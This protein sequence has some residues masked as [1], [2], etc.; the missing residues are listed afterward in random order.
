[1]IYRHAFVLIFLSL[2][3]A[4]TLSADDFP[5]PF[6]TEKSPAKLTTP[7]DALNGMTVPEG[8]E[9]SLF[10]AEPDVNQPIALA[11]DDR[12]RLWV[13][14][15]YTYSESA[16]NYD[17]Q[18][19]DRVVILE[20]AD[21]DGSF[22]KRTVFWD[23]G[24]RLTSVEVGH[25]GVW[26]LDAPN[27]LFIPDANKDDVPDGEPVVMLDGWD[28]NAARHT[29]VNGLRWGPDGWLYGR[30][31]I[32]AISNVGIPGATADQRTQIDCGIWR[33]HPTRRKF[34]VVCVG[35]TNP[36][37]MDWDE[38]GQMFF[39][40]TVI[41]HLWHV[42]P[43]ARFR[44][45]YGEHFNPHTYG[46]IE[47]TADHFHWDTK[48]LWH[49][50]RKD[51]KT[52]MTKTTDQA[53]GGHAH[54]G[55]TILQGQPFPEELH[56]S[57]LALNLHGRRINRD[58]L[59]RHGATYTAKHAPDFLKV[60]DPWYRGVE[61]ICGRVGE[62]FIAD[63]SDV[64][65]CHENDGIHRTSGRIYRLTVAGDPSKHRPNV[66]PADQLTSQQLAEL[67]A[68]DWEWLSRKCLLELAE[69]TA[70]GQDMSTTHDYL[71]TKFHSN[72][73]EQSR[74]RRLWALNATGGTNQQL[75]LDSLDDTSEHVLCWAIRFLTEDESLAKS[76]L[77]KFASMAKNDE[78]GLVLTWLASALQSLRHEDRWPI[79]QALASHGKYAD[80]RVL[81]LMV[82]YGVEPAVLANPDQAIELALSS[83][84]PI[85]REYIARRITLE[86]ERQPTIIE[87]LLQRSSQQTVDD[88]AVADILR[89]MTEALRGWRKATPVKG[90]DTFAKANSS[91]GNAE[92]RRLNRELS[93]VFGDGRALDELRKIAADG[94][95]DLSE[96]RAAIRALVLARDKD[97]VKLLQALLGNRDMSRDAI[98]G[99]AAFGHEETPQLLV[100]KFGSFNVTAKQAAITTLVSRPQFASVLLDAVTDGKIDRSQ[101]SAFQLRQMQNSG[102]SGLSQRVA[103]MWPELAEQ[104]KEKT[105]HIAELRT[106][107]T[108]DTIAKADTSAGRALFNK[109]C[110]SCHTLFGE[111]KK[112]APDLTGAQRNNLNYLLENIVDP[113]A[114]VSKNFKLTVALL[115]DGRVLNGVVVGNSEKTLTLQTATDQVVVQRDEVEELIESPVSMMP[116]KLL[117]V[118]T[119]E[120]VQNLIAYLMSPT[121]VPLPE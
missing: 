96:R 85:V 19:R 25:G 4:A 86:I 32:M 7:Q 78:S 37:G 42:V 28:D 87:Q 119:D 91:N 45:M 120:Q 35:T 30:N 83:K 56:G 99:L 111:G 3:N 16:T 106:M 46:I 31:G 10:A 79:A 63:W 82:W 41:G 33:F 22:D 97:V 51:G 18:M 49:D 95:A 100:S 94:G 108:A 38:N 64:G 17:D 112:I 53:G 116:D 75:L 109:S 55:M 65:E 34:E 50:I 89:G 80:D 69:R 15:N 70:A 76:A 2:F 36:W 114:T 88:T 62:V 23:Q 113:S 93:L 60:A 101:L 115:E 107:L 92:V 11:T 61:I 52:I 39:I 59:H 74:L 1:M 58:T 90:W 26:V 44:R 9:V 77:P 14:E 8:F 67:V 5:K 68:S 43:G 84:L 103:D 73:S 48:E 121:Q 102:N 24:R 117:N 110:A 29:I 66:G 12:G 118:L 40:N 81:P 27:L 71:T 20:D 72:E 104:S 47:Q 6:N 54:C 21:G 13:A 98:N 57:V 105:A